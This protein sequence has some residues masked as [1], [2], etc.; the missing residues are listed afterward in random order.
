MSINTGMAPLSTTAFAVD[1]K[2][3]DESMTRKQGW[4]PYGESK[5]NVVPY[6]LNYV[7]TFNV[8]E[9]TWKNDDIT[10]YSSRDLLE[11]LSIRYNIA[12]DT[13]TIKE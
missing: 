8:D 7:F 11:L 13:N 4:F 2:V 10:D 9:N 3:Y 5:A 1:T 6:L 12:A